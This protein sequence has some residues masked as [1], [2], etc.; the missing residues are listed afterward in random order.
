MTSGE[1]P[2][3]RYAKP[4]V[5]PV[6]LDLLGG[7]TTGVIHLPRHLKWSGSPQYDLDQ[8]GRMLDLYRAVINEAATPTDLHTYLDRDTLVRLWVEM[9]LPDVVRQ[10]W[11]SRFPELTQHRATAA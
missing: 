5:V 11:E 2:H 4:V 6:R 7:P 10:S 3:R 8:P 1:A 9:W